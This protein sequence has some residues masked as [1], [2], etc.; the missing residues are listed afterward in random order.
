MIPLLETFPISNIL[1]NIDI[2][3]SCTSILASYNKGRSDAL[4]GKYLFNAKPALIL[5]YLT[6]Y[7]LDGIPL[8]P[9]SYYTWEH[10]LIHMMD[11]DYISELEYN[12]ERPDITEILVEFI[13][14]FR[15]EGISELFYFMKNH[16]QYRSI[17]A[18]RT[19]FLRKM[20]SLRNRPWD[21]PRFVK[22]SRLA[23]KG[24]NDYYTIGTWMV[25]H[26]LGCKANGKMNTEAEQVGVKIKKRQEISD[27][28]IISMVKQSL[29]ID[30]HSFLDSLT[31]PGPDGKPFVDFDE[32]Y[33]L[34]RHVEICKADLVRR[35]RQPAQPA[36]DPKILNLFRVL[37][38]KA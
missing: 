35:W 23:I 21:N 12:L 10:E 31:K 30:N 27:E 17:K 25:L 5:D 9:S 19:V 14:S 22:N 6:S 38:P 15:S 37:R 33:D 13:L 26:V 24:D 4:A 16:S 11:H 18:A 36:G 2:S 1:V 20:E 28:E 29:E 7:F 3:G 34:A 32:L 8:S